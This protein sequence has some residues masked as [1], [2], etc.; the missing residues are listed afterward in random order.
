MAA[1]KTANAAANTEE[2]VTQEKVTEYKVTVK[3]NPTYCGTG[4]GGAQFANGEAII[5]DPWLAEW[6]RTHEGY[7][8]EEV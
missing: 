8:V 5:N 6:F 7:V 1:R 3:D 2:N 4:A